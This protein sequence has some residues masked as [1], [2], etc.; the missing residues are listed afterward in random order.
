MIRRSTRR[1][2]EP[3]VEPVFHPT[4]RRLQ[5]QICDDA[6]ARLAGALMARDWVARSDIEGFSTAS[7]GALL[8]AAVIT[9]DGP[10]VCSKSNV[11]EGAVADGGS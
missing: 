1:Y 11:V 3:I 10:W 8:K 7:M 5:T 9:T 6:C 2:L 4:P